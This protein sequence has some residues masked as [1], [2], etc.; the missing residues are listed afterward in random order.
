M[1]KLTCAKPVCVSGWFLLCVCT[2]VSGPE[3]ISATATRSFMAEA[4]KPYNYQNA[5]RLLPSKA[6]PTA[7]QLELKQVF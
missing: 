4:K 3:V 5:L 6:P 1:G 2:T 7:F